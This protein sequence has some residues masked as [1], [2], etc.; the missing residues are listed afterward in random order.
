M[1]LSGEIRNPVTLI[2]SEYSLLTYT[3]NR[4]LKSVGGSQQDAN[5][6]KNLKNKKFTH[7]E[8]DLNDLYKL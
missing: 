6:K 7:F 1:V 2:E 5:N 4:G 8:N 3:E